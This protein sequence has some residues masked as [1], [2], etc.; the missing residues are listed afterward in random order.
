MTS[1]TASL[2]VLEWEFPL[3]RPH[4][5]VPLGNGTLGVLVWGDDALCL[6]LARA[7]FWDR[8]AGRPFGS[9]TTFARVRELWEAGRETE[10][11]ALF[12]EDDE[13]GAPPRPL[14]IGGARL[15][16]RFEGDFAPRRARLHLPKGELEVEL[17]NSR[18]ESKTLTLWVHPDAEL[19]V[20][21]GASDAQLTLRPS[22]EWVGAQLEEWGFEPPLALSIQDGAGF[23][24]DVPGNEAL[25]MVWR[26][27]GEQIFVAT[28]LDG[29]VEEA[30]KRAV[31]T[32]RQLPDTRP[33]FFWNAYWRDVPRVELPD[34]QLNRQWLLGL[35]KQA[36]LTAPGGVAAT[37]Q[38]PWME[39]Y[40]LPPWSNDYHFNINVQLLYYPALMTNRA[41]H[42]E[43][44]WAM[45]REWMPTLRSS[46]EAF[47]E[48][49]GALMLPHA[50][51]DRCEVVGQFWT[52]TID[53]ACTAWVGQMAWLHF[54]YGGDQKL[55]REVAWPLLKG[56]FEGYHAMSEERDGRLS[57]PMS[58]SPEYRGDSMNAAGRDASFQLAAWHMTAQILAQAA[59]ILGEPLDPRWREVEE[60]LP[61]WSLVGS[62]EHERIGLWEGLELEESHRHHSHLAAIWPFGSVDPLDHAP[63]VARSLAHWNRLGAGMW[64][65]WCLPW[66]SIVC[67]RFDLPDAAL[68]W[69]GWLDHFSNVGGG[70]RHN[71]DFSGVAVFDNG[72]MFSRL[73]YEDEP[74]VMQMDASMGFL[75][76]VC[77]L[78]VQC[79][80]DAI[81]VLPKLPRKWK[82]LS[83]DGIRTE[84]GF[85]VGAT[86]EGGQTREVR[87]RSELG[88]ALK[89]APGLGNSFRVDGQ[90]TSGSRWEGETVQGQTLIFERA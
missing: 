39:E 68:A 25:A 77:E 36:G 23:I 7:G 45:I 61:L 41:Q 59:P 60:R 27:R 28:A 24:Q 48:R 46:G 50:V 47:F 65:G 6:T 82:R 78:L 71:A 21:E 72:E 35:W 44:L 81:H 5:G 14:Q 52:G 34:A 40:Q 90:P 67:S 26:R 9:R 29:E 17:F 33:E 30:G 80:R 51:D 76:A 85:L 63:V 69:L 11:R 83:F 38:G 20:L 22:W 1:T 2:S 8:R 66:A 16:V 54:R 79:R 73:T 19:C 74:E 55:L 58:V 43:P 75:I 37:L 10:L 49:E 84:G 3:P 89:L 15:E 31:A 12:A 32:A 42:F 13:P 56:A 62:P 53:H 18:G 4:C 88:G 87:V 57:L 70:T 86:V 64:T